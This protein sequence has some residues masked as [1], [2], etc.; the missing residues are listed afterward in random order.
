[1]CMKRRYES[2][3][4]RNRSA[5]LALVVA[6][7][8]LLAACSGSRGTAEPAEPVEVEPVPINWSDFETFDPGSYR[9]PPPSD[10]R[11]LTH[12]VPDKLME[13]R[14]ARGVT[15]TVQGF[16][17]QIFSSQD[18]AAVDEL[19]EDL[20]AWWQEQRD[21]GATTGFFRPERPPVSIHYRQPYYR[22]RVGGFATREQ[23]ERVVALLNARFPGA[24]P[25]PD[26]VTIT[27]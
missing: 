24:F 25:V 4:S 2:M 5:G 9:E 11:G 1:M 8:L 22:V 3:M 13:S 16:R 20:H 18:K 23:A 10:E 21:E 12:E 26:T 7:S 19:V 15:R 6:C 27:Q 14:A 17:V